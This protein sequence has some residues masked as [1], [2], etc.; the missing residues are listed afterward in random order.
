MK[1]VC[2]RA[3]DGEKSNLRFL[4]E[5]N[6]CGGS[7]LVRFLA[8]QEVSLRVTNLA[9]SRTISLQE[10]CERLERFSLSLDRLEESADFDVLKSIRIA[11]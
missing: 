1:T 3:A 8:E 5:R 4:A 11:E 6:Q 7:D 9:A 10:C 2:V